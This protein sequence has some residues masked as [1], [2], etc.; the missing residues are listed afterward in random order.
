[1]FACSAPV[2]DEPLVGLLP[3]HPPEALHEVALAADHVI[4]EPSPFT[5]VVGFAVRATVGTGEPTDTVA[6]CTA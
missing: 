5:T 1:V 6:D 2:D 3:D 4:V